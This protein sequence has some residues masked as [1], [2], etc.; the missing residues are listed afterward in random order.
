MYPRLGSL[1]KKLMYSYI[2]ADENWC[3]CGILAPV[4]L[5]KCLPRSGQVNRPVKK[6]CV[7][8]QTGALISVI[9][10]M[11]SVYVLAPIHVENR[12]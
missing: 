9:V 2:R 5:P 11:Q 7:S 4:R 1:A 10:V 6:P 12:K 3:L 8:A